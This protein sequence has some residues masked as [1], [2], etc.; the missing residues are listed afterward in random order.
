MATSQMKIAQLDEVR[1]EKL[2]TLEAELG[3]QI[4]ALEQVARPAQLSAEQFT[5]LQSVEK[6]LGVNLVAFEPETQLR[7]AT[8]SPEQMKRLQATEK[9]M[10]FLLVAYELTR[11]EYM[12]KDAALE[13]GMQPVQ[14]SEAQY[15]RLQTVEEQIGVVLMAYAPAQ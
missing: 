4:V 13:Q 14:L 11:T 9:E 6:E 10:H 1:A 12:S 15:A 5:R 8:P 3:C 7:L 2:R